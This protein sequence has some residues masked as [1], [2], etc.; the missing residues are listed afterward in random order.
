LTGV[1]VNVTLPPRHIDVVVELIVKEVACVGLTV[2]VPLAEE[3]EQLV[4]VLVITT[5]YGP[6]TDEVNVATLPGSVAVGGT[7]HT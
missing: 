5:L 6:A 2:T 1:A 4:V 3:E 7:V